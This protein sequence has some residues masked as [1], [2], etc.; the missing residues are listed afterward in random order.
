MPQRFTRGVGLNTARAG[1]AGTYNLTSTSAVSLGFGVTIT[2]ESPGPVIAASGGYGAFTAGTPPV[3]AAFNILHS[4]VGIP[5]QGSATGGGDTAGLGPVGQVGEQTAVGASNYKPWW[6]ETVF[7][8]LDPT[9]THY[10]YM[11]GQILTGTTPTFA[12][13]GSNTVHLIITEV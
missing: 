2:L 10:F 9:V 13:S 6:T 12:F 1:I 3:A 11:Y 7:N 5:T 8:G 4:T